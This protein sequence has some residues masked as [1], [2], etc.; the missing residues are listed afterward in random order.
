M[1]GTTAA[2]IARLL[3]A[4]ET[5]EFPPR[6]ASILWRPSG[7]TLDSQRLEDANRECN[8]E[9]RWAVLIAHGILRAVNLYQMS[10]VVSWHE[11]CGIMNRPR[12]PFGS[13]SCACG[14]FD[15]FQLAA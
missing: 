12:R 5:S 14:R 11:V 9:M 8:P 1:T 6:A 3:R 4:C 13:L 7:L 2:G 15:G 10:I